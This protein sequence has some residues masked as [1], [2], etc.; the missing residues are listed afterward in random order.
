[1]QKLQ[2]TTSVYPEEVSSDLLGC[3][4][5]LFVQKILVVTLVYPEEVSCDLLGCDAN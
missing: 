3:D 4:A 5:N 1:V 2:V